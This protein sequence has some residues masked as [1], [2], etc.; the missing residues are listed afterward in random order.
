MNIFVQDT[1]TVPSSTTEIFRILQQGPIGAAVVLKNIGS[2][3]IT[4]TFQES[5]DTVTWSDIT[6]ATG[7]L[8][9]SGSGQTALHK[10]TSALAVLRLVASGDSEIDFSVTRYATRASGGALPLLAF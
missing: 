3:N 1:N 9:P 5:S 10:I 6:G 8:L 4:Y 7:T 2:N